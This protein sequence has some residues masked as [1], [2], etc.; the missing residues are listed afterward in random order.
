MVDLTLMQTC[1]NGDTFGWST[2]WECQRNTFCFAIDSLLYNP[3][4]ALRLSL[5]TAKEYL[6]DAS[7]SP[8]DARFRAEFA[9]AN[10]RL[11][12]KYLAPLIY[13]GE[14]WIYETY[15]GNM[16]CKWIA[17]LSLFWVLREHK[18][19]LLIKSDSTP[20]NYPSATPVS[21]LFS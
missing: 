1:M 8:R 14:G 6:F 10:S 7:K 11:C 5:P 13:A 9:V 3:L 16:G 17:V 2:A 19:Q 20:K 18:T 12:G 4:N 21:K 15:V